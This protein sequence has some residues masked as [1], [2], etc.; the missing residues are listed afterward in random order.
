MPRD[1]EGHLIPGRV[2]PFRSVPKHI[3]RP[4]YVGKRGPAKYTGSDVYSDE[5]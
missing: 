5:A 2:S 1:S 4:E 3:A